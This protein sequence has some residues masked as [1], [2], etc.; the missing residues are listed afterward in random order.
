MVVAEILT[1]VALVKQATDFIKSNISTIKDISEIGQQI[2]D[3]FRGEKEA[4]QA[5]NKKSGNR[6]ADQF[7]V[8]NVAREVID[9]KLAQERLQEVATMIDMRLDRKSTRLNSSHVRT[10]RMPSSA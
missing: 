5:R 9:A 8:E 1:G 4:Q 2:D 6:L 3:L 7:G 10:S